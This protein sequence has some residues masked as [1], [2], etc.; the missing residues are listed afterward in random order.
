MPKYSEEVKAKAVEMA[1]NGTPL[2]KITE[3]LG[4]NPK[5]IQRYCEKAGVMLPKKERKSKAKAAEEV[6][7]E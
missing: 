5:A 3:E 6:S 1:K 4:P 7:E 2:T